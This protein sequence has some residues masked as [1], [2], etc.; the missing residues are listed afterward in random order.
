MTLDA[1]ALAPVQPQHVPQHIEALTRANRVR[2]A[3]A[4]L[5]RRVAD[6]RR[7]AAEVI[8]TCPWMTET[9]SLGEL[10]SSQCRWGRTRTHKVLKSLGLTEA[11]L[12]S[13]LTERQRVTLAALLDAKR[14]S[15]QED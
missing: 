13:A 5:K 4:D 11:K 15:R 9:M 3:R 14:R 8:L 1:A 7:D 6:G 12:V 2:L 10:L